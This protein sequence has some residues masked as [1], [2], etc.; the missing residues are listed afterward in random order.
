M[1]IKK[2]NYTNESERYDDLFAEWK[3]A[4]GENAALKN[5]IDAAVA[6][7]NEALGV[8]DR[9]AEHNPRKYDVKKIELLDKIAGLFMDLE[10]YD[11]AGH[12]FSEALSIAETNVGYDKETFDPELFRL[13]YSLG[14]CNSENGLT[15]EA[16]RCYSN[17]LKIYD[18]MS[19]SNT[20]SLECEYASFLNT[21]C[22]F[23]W[24]CG[25]N[26]NAESCLL[27]AHT[28]L[29]R[30]SENGDEKSHEW[31]KITEANIEKFKTLFNW[32]S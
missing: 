21:L 17:M 24:K 13:N 28:I 16:N 23:Y 6:N 31:L 11:K 26:V 20:A 5:D 3:K 19:A 18:G 12:Y 15:D 1:S 9:L 32:T 10:E 25:D 7:Y 8:I 30:L 27:K 2:T 14:F 29:Q 4:L 22:H